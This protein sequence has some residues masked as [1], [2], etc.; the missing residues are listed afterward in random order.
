MIMMA[1]LGIWFS[2]KKRWFFIGKIC[3]KQFFIFPLFFLV[4]SLHFN[5]ILFSMD[6]NA[7]CELN[8][9]CWVNP[10]DPSLL[11]VNLLLDQ[12]HSPE[13]I[14][15]WSELCLRKEINKCA[16]SLWI[17]FYLYLNELKSLL[18]FKWLQMMRRISPHLFMFINWNKECICRLIWCS[19][20]SYL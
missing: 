9:N 1:T 4:G 17:L 14:V 8:A 3:F 12:R 20:E 15:F 18:T 2:C 13:L 19:Y 11:C 10:F 7:H 16:I 6:L 5:L